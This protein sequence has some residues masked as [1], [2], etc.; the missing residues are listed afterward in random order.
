MIFRHKYLR[1]GGVEYNVALALR[2]TLPTAYAPATLTRS[3]ST[4]I[5]LADPAR[6]TVDVTVPAG[7]T[8][9]QLGDDVQVSV[10]GREWDSNV[11]FVGQVESLARTRR[12]LRNADGSTFQ[13]TVY[14][15]AATDLFG[16]LARRTIGDEPWPAE[17]VPDR[18]NRIRALV[19][20]VPM[21]ERADH[22]GFDF[23][24]PRDV[25]NTSAL[26]LLRDTVAMIDNE[27]FIDVDGQIAYVPRN[28]T[29]TA[30]DLWD[31]DESE[32]YVRGGAFATIHLPAT[33]FADP[34]DVLDYDLVVNVARVTGKQDG[35]EPGEYADR[36]VT[37]TNAES[38]ARHGESTWSVTGD[39]YADG[40]NV[41][42]VD[43]MPAARRARRLVDSAGDP[44]WRLAG[45]VQVV[46][47]LVADDG[48]G[49]SW[50]T[51]LLDAGRMTPVVMLD[52]APEGRDIWRVIGLQATWGSDA[53]E[54]LALDVEPYEM[55][56]PLGLTF[57]A[58]NTS[59]PLTFAQSAPM[60]FR[61]ARTIDAIGFT[62]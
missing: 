36:I 37:F 25:D 60:T 23:V 46:P 51:Q 54:A 8:P 62:D 55:A 24:A 44:L 52:G 4:G 50:I 42:D 31:P 10:V 5:D 29:I 33:A 15:V 2:E 57:T 59:P 22:S 21:V 41:P 19:P 56:G 32:P 20:D 35:T 38:R 47:H 1:I 40:T 6:F 13:A 53:V 16:V 26:Q 28:Q 3:R 58:V 48:G 18:W 17:Q 45:Q 7:F 11:S 39:G 49:M 43:A 34:G 12:V 9:P 27:L 61:Q 14:E 30:P